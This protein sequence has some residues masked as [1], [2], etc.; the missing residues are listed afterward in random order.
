MSLADRP[1]KAILGFWH[2]NQ[3]NVVWHQAIR[4]NL[5]SLFAAPLGHQFQV[6]RIVA[7][8]EKRLLSAIAA[9]RNVMRQTR[10]DQPCQSCHPKKTI[11]NYLSSQY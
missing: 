4:P 7:I 2:C 8:V 3:M 1:P 9:L 5:Y 11:G 10:D 6:G